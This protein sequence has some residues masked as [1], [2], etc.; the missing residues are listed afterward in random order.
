LKLNLFSGFYPFNPSLGQQIQTD[1]EGTLADRAFIAHVQY[2]AAVATAAGTAAVLALFATA[3]G[4]ATVKTTGFTQPTCPRVVTATT[5]GTA[6]DIKAVQVLLEGTNFADEVITETLPVFTENTK[7][8]VTGAK[9]F[10]TI[11]KVTV[12]AMDG[13]A[14]TVSIGVGEVLGLPY[15]LTHNTVLKAYLGNALEGTAPTVTVSSTALGSNT[16]DLNSSLNGSIVD[17]Y[18]MV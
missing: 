18:L 4:A 10:K 15:K 6:A 7:T 8:T 2:S 1:V 11:T 16:V 12:P 5:D 14:A 13:D 3:S 17:V 9:A